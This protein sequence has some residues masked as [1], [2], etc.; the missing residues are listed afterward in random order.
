MEW[1]HTNSHQQQ[2]LGPEEDF[3]QSS[4]VEIG[5]TVERVEMVEMLNGIGEPVLTMGSEN[6]N[7][8]IRMNQV[9]MIMLK[10]E[11]L[12]ITD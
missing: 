11:C 5:K 9:S 1:Q 6:W 12:L 3:V 8:L 7:A 4:V 2:R 10:W